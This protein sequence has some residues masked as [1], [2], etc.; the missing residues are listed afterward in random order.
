ML[1][2]IEDATPYDFPVN[3]SAMCLPRSYL[4]VPRGPSAYESSQGNQLRPCLSR[5]GRVLAR[6]LGSDRLGAWARKPDAAM[7]VHHRDLFGS[8]RRAPI[9][10][11]SIRYP[12]S[13]IRNTTLLNTNASV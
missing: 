8:V 10:L 11:I 12:S 9:L 7:V 13:A 4:I 1:V 3:L 2:A 5:N 6:V